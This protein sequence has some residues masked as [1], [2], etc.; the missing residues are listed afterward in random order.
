MIVPAARAAAAIGAGA[1]PEVVTPSVN[2]TITRALDEPGS[3][4]ACAFLNASPWF[5][6]PPASIASTASFSCETEWFSLR[7]A[8]AA[9]LEPYDI[10]P[11]PYSDYYSFSAGE[12]SVLLL[13]VKEDRA[14]DISFY[15]AEQGGEGYALGG[16]LY[17]MGPENKPLVIELPFDGE[18]SAYFI[19]FED[20][21]G[22][23]RR[24]LLQMGGIDPAEG[25]PYTLTEM[26]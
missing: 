11:E 3:N 15:A 5:V 4:S 18:L 12:G 17:T 8:C 10:Y 21:N 22:E 16:L 25:C 23:V 1:G 14:R 7:D 9:A 19:S 13:E 6:P 26:D 20:E 24:L 2:M